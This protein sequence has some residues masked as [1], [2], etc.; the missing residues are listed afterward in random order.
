M[1]GGCVNLPPIDSRRIFAWTDPPLPPGWHGVRWIPGQ[2]D[3]TAIIIH[4]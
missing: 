2:G 4:P 1:S 3:S